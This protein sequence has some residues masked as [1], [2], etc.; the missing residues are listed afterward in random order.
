MCN[1]DCNQGRR[2]PARLY[3]GVG[4]CSDLDNLTPAPTSE[5]T[6]TGRLSAFE[7][8]IG[9]VWAVWATLMLFAVLDL[10]M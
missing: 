1:R 7:V 2:C 6:Q 9:V 4:K 3:P 10:T 8:V 5:P